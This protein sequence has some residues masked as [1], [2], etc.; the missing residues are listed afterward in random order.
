MPVIA[1]A[2]AEHGYRRATTAK[3]A[4]ACGVRENVLYRLW[5]DKKAMFVATIE[6]MYRLSADAWSNVIAKV[7]PG[8]SAAERVLAYSSEHHGELGLYK[9]I[10][11]GLT[12][13]DDP[14]V[15]KALRDMYARFHKFIAQQIAVHRDENNG[16]I[17]RNV[18]LAA[19]AFVG[20]G[21]VVGIGRELELLGPVQRKNLM[22]EMGAL[23]L[24][25]GD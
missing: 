20:L 7:G 1:R 23:L 8:Q 19:W 17:P 10:F 12:E 3:L 6:Y 4:E 2:F 5:P 21:T 18:E 24:S 15:Q 16:K 25:G 13:T 11:A 22:R 14:D 9:L